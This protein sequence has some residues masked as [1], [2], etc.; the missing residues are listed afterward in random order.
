MHALTIF[1]RAS[2]ILLILSQFIN[3]QSSKSKPPDAATLRTKFVAAFGKDFDLVKDKMTTRAVERG[4]GLYWLAFVKPKRA[5]YFSL[6]YRYRE[7]DPLDI[8]EHEIRFTIGPEKCHRGTPDSG[9]YGRFCLGDTLIVPVLVNNYPGHEFKLA[10]AEYANEKED[11]PESAV[12]SLSLD[13]STIDN[14]AAL[15]LRYAGRTAHKMLH[16]IPGYTLN[17]YAEFVAAS[18]GRMNLLITTSSPGVDVK[19]YEGVPIIVLPPGAPATLI[20]GREEVRGYRKGFD[21]REYLASTSGNS[22]MT[23]VLI[24]QPG[25][26]ILVIYFSIVR[27]SDFVGGRFGDVGRDSS[28]S[29]KPLINVRP[30]APDARYDFTEWIVD[31]LPK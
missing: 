13:Q 6:Q 27:R 26:R 31:Y 16:R 3:A 18:P 4:G 7:S 24:L 20:A 17:L 12:D 9:V 19:G 1:N 21:G 2:L 25:D 8:R 5:G 15:T 11:P 23:N 10:R 14:P 22:Y 29:L 30:F 28:E